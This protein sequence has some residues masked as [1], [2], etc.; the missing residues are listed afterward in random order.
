MNW[1]ALTIHA[2]NVLFSSCYTRREVGPA[3]LGLSMWNVS[4]GY[5]SDCGEREPGLSPASALYHL[6]GLKQIV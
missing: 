4:S 1:F 6:Q 3:L 2:G 5:H